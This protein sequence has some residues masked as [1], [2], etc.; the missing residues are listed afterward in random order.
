MVEISI[1]FFILKLLSRKP[2]SL[3]IKLPAIISSNKPQL[4][5][6]EQLQAPDFF[7]GQDCIHL[8]QQHIAEDL[9]SIELV[10][11]GASVGNVTGP[12]CVVQ[13]P[14]EGFEKLPMGHILV[15]STTDPS[16][17]PLFL[18]VGLFLVNLV[19]AFRLLLWWWSME[20]YCLMVPLQLENLAF[21]L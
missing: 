4:Q 1:F 13:T 3:L 17:T 14:A 9:H 12:A 6:L 5:R 19:I 2:D 20:A 10:G 18:K 11:I 15:C 8:P 21:L 7:V 16:W